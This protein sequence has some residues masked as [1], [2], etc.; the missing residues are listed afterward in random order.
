[1]NRVVSRTLLLACLGLKDYF[2]SLKN[3]TQSCDF[4]FASYQTTWD[5]SLTEDLDCRRIIFFKLLIPNQ[6][7]AIEDNFKICL[8]V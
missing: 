4:I 3:Y 6:K 1:M 5:L 8:N 7:K 2:C